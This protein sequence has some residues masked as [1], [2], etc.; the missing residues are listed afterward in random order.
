MVKANADVREAMRKHKVPAW[1]IGKVLN[2][3]ENT[4]LRRLRTEL[5]NAEKNR[6]FKI[7]DRIA[8]ENSEKQERT[9]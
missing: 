5:S 1:A 3:H 8:E 4:V 6:L 2:V 7:I 9:A